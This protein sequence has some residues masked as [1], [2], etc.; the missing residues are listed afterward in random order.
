M[1][2][3][4]MRLTFSDD[5]VKR[6]PEW[7]RSA[8]S[9]PNATAFGATFGLIAWSFTTLPVAAKY[10]CFQHFYEPWHEVRAYDQLFVITTSM[11]AEALWVVL[12]GIAAVV[13]GLLAGASLDQSIEPLPAR[14]RIG[15]RAYSAY[16]RASHRANGRFWLLPLGVGGAALTPAILRRFERWQAL[17]VAL[18]FLTFIA[19]VWA[20]AANGAA[21]LSR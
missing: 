8:L 13:D 4:G 1:G 7:K 3:Q 21:I 12:L 5:V 15:V 6:R 19:T 11:S 2:R 16:S 10:P 9:A 18:Q 14:H 20:L 17:R